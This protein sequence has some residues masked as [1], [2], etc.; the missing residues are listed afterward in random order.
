MAELGTFSLR[1]AIFIAAYAVLIDITGLWR[2]DNALIKSARNATWA[3]WLCLSAA[4][5]VLLI[6]LVNCDFSINY[7]A[8]HT[9]KALP[10]AYRLSALWAGAAGSL[11]LWLWMQVGLS[12]LV[13]SKTTPNEKNYAAYARITINV[14]SC[15][16]LVVLLFDKNVFATSLMPP[17]DGA[18]L[19]PLL[20]H[21]AMVLHPP[22]LFIGYAAYIIPF[23]WAIAVMVAPYSKT[24]PAF[25][26]QARNW[27]LVAWL[28]LTIGNALGSWWA[29]EELGWGGFWAWDPVE[30]S[31]LMPWLIGTALLHSFKRFR[32]G[33]GTG[34]WV[35]VLS[36]LTYSFCIFG[37]FLTRY[38]LVSSVHAFPDP[39]LGILFLI[40]LALVWLLVAFLALRRFRSSDR[41]N[42]AKTIKGDGI[43]LSV[44]WILSILVII[45]LVGTLFPFFSGLLSSDK[46]SLQPEF[47]T[48]MTAPAGL[49][50]LLLIGLCPY[51]SRYGLKSSW[52]V[53]LGVIIAVASVALWFIY[54]ALA[55]PCFVICGYVML[56]IIADF[57]LRRG[58]GRD[59]SDKPLA[60]RRLSWYGAR[61][62]HI[63]VVMMFLG[64]AG[65]EGYSKE[66]LAALRPGQ[67]IAVGSYDISF[68]KI[69]REEGPNF[70]LT[71]AEI[72]VAKAGETFTMKPALSHY[73]GKQTTSEVDIK[74]S[75]AGDLYIALTAVE[76]GDRLINLRILIKPLINWLW[77]GS[78]VLIIGTIIVL[79]SWYGNRK[80]YNKGDN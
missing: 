33:A 32:P 68:D 27:M 29:Y 64:I 51:I 65:S 52:R 8:A 25:F 57:F 46:I 1:L 10:L 31:S 13:F 48:K 41:V 55:V 30:N 7:V 19:N 36:L 44:N 79:I 38:G 24:R 12:A 15:F 69:T 80:K 2:R 56:N 53:I 62:A 54:K 43:I 59:K 72:S 61:L 16:F 71:V 47:F 78:I 60:R 49:L 20:Q 6:A 14:I 76:Q 18:G 50:L 5:V 63:G 26:I 4:I 58:S 9:S 22:T 35:I 28:F 40:L 23:A 39:G 74:R 67:S 17:S 11:L 66:E 37:T 75:L 45:I 73:E 3:C 77:L 70:S 42:S 34:R 21:P